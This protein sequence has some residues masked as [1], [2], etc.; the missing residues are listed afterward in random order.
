M[1]GGGGV[2]WV[3]DLAERFRRGGY[4][5][6]GGRHCVRRRSEEWGGPRRARGRGKAGVGGALLTQT[7]TL[8]KASGDSARSQANRLAASRRPR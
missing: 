1:P 7:Q 3:E 5:G 8:S 2:P 6:V 4:V